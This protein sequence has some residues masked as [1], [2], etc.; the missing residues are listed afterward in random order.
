MDC[1]SGVSKSLVHIILFTSLCST[2][3]TE[4]RIV[5]HNTQKKLSKLIAQYN[6]LD[7]KPRERKL[8]CG[9]SLISTRYVLTAAHCLVGEIE[10][11]VGEL[12]V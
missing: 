8:S 10:R 1:H 9:G 11:K 7:L 3:V 6:S 12:Y 5:M 2:E 4:Y